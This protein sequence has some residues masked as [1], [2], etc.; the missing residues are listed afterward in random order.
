MSYYGSAKE[1][2]GSSSPP[3][4]E[5]SGYSSESSGFLSESSGSQPP[6]YE[7]DSSSSGLSSG[8]ISSSGFGSSDGSD[9]P[10][11]PPPPG[12]ESESS[13]SSSSGERVASFDLEILELD[14][15]ES[16]PPEAW[17]FMRF[18]I[19]NDGT[20]QIEITAITI[21]PPI[22]NTLIPELPVL[23]EPGGSSEWQVLGYE[24]FYN[25]EITATARATD[26]DEVIGPW[27]FTIL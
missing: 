6:D 14:Y 12:S 20:V 10:P 19:V 27:Q 11:D 4:S 22:S 26:N 24:D 2:S 18:R 25:G 5:S 23:L 15:N 13:D 3:E 7:S 17:G 1:S 21:D 8:G 9:H 16:F